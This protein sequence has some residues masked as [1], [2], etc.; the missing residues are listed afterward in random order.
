MLRVLLAN[1]SGAPQRLAVRGLGTRVLVRL[2]DET[3]AE[4]AMRDP[5]TF[6]AQPGEEQAAEDGMLELAL[7]PYA[8]VRIDSD[9]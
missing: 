8:V 6:R 4:A 1:L 9:T 7:R 3:N 2:L 5:E